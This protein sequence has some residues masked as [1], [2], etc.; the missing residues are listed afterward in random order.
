MSIESPGFVNTRKIST[1]ATPTSVATRTCFSSTFQ[2]QRS[3]ANFLKPKPN[4][5]IASK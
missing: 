1:T 2:F 5:G 4:S 3:A